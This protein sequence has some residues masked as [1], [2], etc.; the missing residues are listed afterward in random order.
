VLSSGRCRSRVTSTSWKFTLQRVSHPKN[1]S[2][3]GG[4]P[5]GGVASPW[6]EISSCMYH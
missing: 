6:D 2:T 4:V 5:S 1:R 3:I